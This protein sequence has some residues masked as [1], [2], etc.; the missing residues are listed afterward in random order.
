M[1]FSSTVAVELLV[2]LEHEYLHAV[3]GEH[4]RGHAVGSAGTDNHR[5]IEELEIHFV[6]KHPR[7]YYQNKPRKNAKTNVISGASIAYRPLPKAR[8]R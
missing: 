2:G 6:G 1:D 4:M 5:V 3:L 7:K 8:S